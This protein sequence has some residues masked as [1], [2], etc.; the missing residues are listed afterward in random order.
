ALQ[1]KDRRQ[2]MQTMRPRFLLLIIVLTLTSQLA[3]ASPTLRVGLKTNSST[4]TDAR[5]PRPKS[6]RKK[7]AN[8]YRRCL[9]AAGKNKAESSSC[10]PRYELCLGYCGQ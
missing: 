9:K 2:A 4:T 10:R 7:C 5:T 3:F 8:S 6:C 1:R